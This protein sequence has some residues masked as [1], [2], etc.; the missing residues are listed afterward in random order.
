MDEE[1]AK[2]S[3]YTRKLRESKKTGLHKDIK[4]HGVKEPVEIDHTD[5]DYPKGFVWEGH[6]RIASAVEINPHM[7]IPVKHKL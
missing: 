6:H 4:A 5:P 1:S 3:I 7:P 2:N